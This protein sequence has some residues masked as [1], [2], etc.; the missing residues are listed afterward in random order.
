MVRETEH[1]TLDHLMEE[2][3]EISFKSFGNR[4]DAENPFLV[5]PPQFAGDTAI[6][7]VSDTD[8]RRQTSAST[9]KML[10]QLF[11]FDKVDSYVALRDIANLEITAAD[12]YTTQD[13]CDNIV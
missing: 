2:K 6:A 8:P 10:I 1:K 7:I 3:Q 9:F 5:C 12:D 4:P 13:L 11:S